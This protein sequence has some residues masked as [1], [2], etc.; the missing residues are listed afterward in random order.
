MHIDENDLDR[1]IVRKIIEQT[2]QYYFAIKMLNNAGDALLDIAHESN[3]LTNM[4]IILVDLHMPL[5]N[6]FQFVQEFEKFPSGIREKYMIY[7][8]TSS[9][10][11]N[12]IARMKAFESV[13]DVLDKPLT[14]H[15]LVNVLQR[16]AS[17][18]K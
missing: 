15:K 13:Q 8:L 18:V 3:G 2:D 9:I 6:G 4:T 11:R 17:V 10:D 14:K 16:A 1:F 12:D 7:A 5:I